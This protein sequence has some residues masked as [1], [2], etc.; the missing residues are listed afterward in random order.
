MEMWA[1][2]GKRAVCMIKQD[3]KSESILYEWNY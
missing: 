2:V 1:I 3:C